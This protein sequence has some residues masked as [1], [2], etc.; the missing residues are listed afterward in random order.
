MSTDDFSAGG[1]ACV[2]PFSSSEL[3]DGSLDQV[4]KYVPTHTGQHTVTLNATFDSALY[5]LTQCTD[6]TSCTTTDDA[7]GSNS[8]ESVVF[9][10][11]VGV[12]VWVIVDG[13]GSTS[14]NGAYT[15]NIESP[16]PCNADCNGKT[17]GDDGCGGTCG[18]CPS[19]EQCTAGQCAAAA[20]GE[21]CANPIVVG[22]LPYTYSGDT[23]NATNDYAYGDNACPGE[24]TGWGDGSNE[25]VFL[26]TPTISGTV[27]FTL[28]P[29]YDST[30]YIVTDCGN[31]DGS[32]LGG[33]DELVT[34]DAEVI[35]LTVDA[36]VP[37]YIFVDGYSNFS[38][39]SGAYVLSIEGDAPCVPVCDTNNC[40]SDGCGGSCGECEQSQACVA[41]QCVDVGQ[42]LPVGADCWQNELECEPG[43]QC[44]INTDYTE[45]TCMTDLNDGDS[46]MLGNGGCGDG[47]TCN[48][49]DTSYSTLQCYADKALGQ[50]CGLGQGSCVDGYSCVP[51]DTQF[52]NY[53]CQADVA[54][55]EACYFGK[56]LCEDGSTCYS[57]GAPNMP[58]KC[59][60]DNG[61]NQPCGQGLG[62]CDED[63][64]CLELADANQGSLCHGFAD[65]GGV[66]GLGV[67]ACA[68]GLGC[69]FMAENDTEGTCQPLLFTGQPC[70][71]GK[72][73]CIGLA[74]C[75]Y[76]VVPSDAVC[77]KKV[78]GGEACGAGTGQYCW[79]GL[80]CV[81]TGSGNTGTC[82]DKCQ[83]QGLYSNGT[84]DTDCMD[85]DPDCY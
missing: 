44:V 33:V 9:D 5:I 1:N 16:G 13:W 32:C 81:A 68:S 58:F 43:T 6:T 46:C 31:I 72:G 47:T 76:T 53:T 37:L 26:F 39:Y 70:G 35:Q 25:Q 28:N 56:G 52:A 50:L 14:A 7:I 8:E 18:D 66:C 3:G 15:L 74:I 23:T 45:F 67:S 79:T 40:G 38:N 20:L 34:A 60:L 83:T 12:P 22:G 41:G 64:V 63:G 73:A 82:Q 2:A 4:W 27:T 29:E 30:F 61:V 17:C 42:T 19:G 51:D 77:V 11:T 48:F 57:T 80:T 84:C 24:S 36:N 21:N 85:P 54:A 49:T 59:Y 75:V 62:G 55:N 71:V 65:Q 78:F 10:G 69:M